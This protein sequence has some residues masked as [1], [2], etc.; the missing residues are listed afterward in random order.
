MKDVF[1]TSATAKTL[2]EAPM[3]YKSIDEI[4]SHIGPTVDV[5]E[6]LRSV[7]NFKASE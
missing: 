3:A 2:D 5:V 6:R 4:L 1:T 7:Y